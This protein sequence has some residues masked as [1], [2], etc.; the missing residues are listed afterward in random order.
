MYDACA[1]ALEHESRV[2][3]V[4]VVCTASS[5]VINVMQGKSDT[6]MSYTYV[7]TMKGT[8]VEDNPELF[9]YAIDSSVLSDIKLWQL[10]VCIGPI[11][12]PAVAFAKPSQ[13]AP[14]SM[15]A[16]AVPQ[17]KSLGAR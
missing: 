1:V 2:Q 8:P 13:C 14:L 11:L 6:S 12:S 4:S 3:E 16:S 9:S 7:T 5:I 10:Q 15:V 17:N